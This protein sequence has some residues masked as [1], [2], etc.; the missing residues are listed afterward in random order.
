M[1]LQITTLRPTPLTKVTEE[2]C[3]RTL[4]HQCGMNRNISRP[5]GPTWEP[6][7]SMHSH[8]GLWERGRGINPWIPIFMGMTNWRKLGCALTMFEQ[9]SSHRWVVGEADVSGECEAFATK[10]WQAAEYR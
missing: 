2:R 8:G 4:P 6:E 10:Q 3:E 5:N 9:S 7:V 1:E